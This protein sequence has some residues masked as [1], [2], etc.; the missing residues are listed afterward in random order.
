M[1][2]RVALLAVVL[3]STAAPQPSQAPSPTASS[4]CAYNTPYALVTSPCTPFTVVAPRVLAALPNDAFGELAVPDKVATLAD[5]SAIVQAGRGGLFRVVGA[6]ITTLWAPYTGC[7]FD[8]PHAAQLIGSFGNTA[9]VL[10]NGLITGVRADGSVAFHWPA[11]NANGGRT[12]AQDNHG[13]VWFA[14]WSGQRDV[15]YAYFPKTGAKVA[16]EPPENVW[17]IFRGAN[18]RVYVTGRGGLFELR[19]Q[20]NVHAQ[21]AY[22]S[23]SVSAKGTEPGILSE[24]QGV[25]R[26]GSLW[27]TTAREIVHRYPSGKSTIL[28]LAHALNVISRVAAP[29]DLTTAPDGAVWTDYG[30]PVRV[31][32]NDRLQVIAEPP[33]E[34]WAMPPAFAPDSS[35]WVV[36]GDTRAQTTEGIVHFTLSP[37][38]R[39]IPTMSLFPKAMEL[40]GPTRACITPTPSPTPSPPPLPPT[41]GAVQFVY[42]IGGDSSNAVFAY[43][44]RSNGSL[45]PVRGSPFATDRSPDSIAIDPSGRFL[46]VSGWER[47]ISAYTIDAT[48]GALLP[49]KGSPFPMPTPMLSERS[50]TAVAVDPNGGY[51]YAHDIGWKAVLSYS[52]DGSSGALTPVAGSPFPVHG[53]PFRLVLNPLHRVAYVVTDR[54]IEIFGTTDGRLTPLGEAPVPNVRGGGNDLAVD[55]RGRYAYITSDAS[56]TIASYSIDEIGMLRLSSERPLKVT[57]SRFGVGPRGIRINH[58]GTFAYVA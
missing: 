28:R 7:D 11:A 37:A 23:N 13:I 45:V 5:G 14:E 24:I 35:G 19:N 18:G 38:G 36:S 56:G 40:H 54:S 16:F 39:S 46:Y 50:P 27:A 30:K 4:T 21:L 53:S 44:A 43:W 1:A 51:L 52:I 2:M 3:V 31:T 57:K 22:G 41:Y 26:D 42:A 29:L 47:R 33:S 34:D 49:V 17:K 32:S 12:V 9:V 25:G 6:R 58:R 55:P 8:P 10:R 20:P 48:T 15:M